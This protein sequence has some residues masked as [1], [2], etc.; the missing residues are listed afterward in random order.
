MIRALLRFALGA[1]AAPA[2]GAATLFAVPIA[3]LA[4]QGVTQSEVVIGAF[5]P[6]TGPLGFLGAGARSGIEMAI[7]EINQNGGINGRKLRLAFETSAGSPA[8]SLAAAK[9]LVE[10]EK[11]F[12]LILAS[13]SVGAAAAA[14]YLREKGVVTYNLIAATPNI[15]IP[16]TRNIFH[17]S[18]AHAK[19]FT[20]SAL[21][22][23]MSFTPK[24]KTVAVLVQDIGYHKAVMEGLK[25]LIQKSGAQLVTMQQFVVDERDFTGQLLAIRTAK[26][27]V[28]MVQGDA[29][30]AALIIKQAAEMRLGKQNWVVAESAITAQFIA[31][32]GP[33]VEGV[34]SSWQFRQYHGEK[35]GDMP[36]FEANWRKLN[37]N[38]PPGRPNYLDLSGYN[39]T[40][41]LAL[42]M[43]GAGTDLT[44]D[45]VI[46]SFESLKDAVPTNFGRWAAD[47]QAPET[48]SAVDHQGNDRQ[49]EISVK[50][51]KWQV[52]P[53]SLRVWANSGQF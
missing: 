33:A 44:W 5:G 31:L 40:Y 42:A 43:K 51:G 37:P 50:D 47:L 22:S 30:P 12:A 2:F 39:G 25:A 41:I 46:K 45:R 13:G 36:K 29:A 35:R 1:L 17:G 38:A 15:H 26:P 18:S 32:G 16:L 19:F 28:I 11:V 9:K 8:E 4:Q 21:E 48:F 7:H 34:K 52:N 10:Q 49:Y 20:Q 3:V 23:L 24:P 14:D 27:D 53:N 6:V